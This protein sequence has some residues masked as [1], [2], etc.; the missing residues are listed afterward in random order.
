MYRRSAYVNEG[1]FFQLLLLGDTAAPFQ[2]LLEEMLD[3]DKALAAPDTGVSIGEQ[4]ALDPAASY[5]ALVQGF[6]TVTAPTGRA[7]EAE[8]ALLFHSGVWR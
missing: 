5:G 3:D 4:L 6:D 8:A 2:P 1:L 7:L